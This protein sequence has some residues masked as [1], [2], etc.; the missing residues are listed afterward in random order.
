MYELAKKAREGMKAKARRLASETVGKVDSSTWSPAPLLRADIKTGARPIMKP[1]KKGI[2]ESNA[3][4][5]TK[6]AIGN[7]TR[8]AFKQGGAV[9]K[10]GGIL[11]KKA[12]G[13]VE[14]MPKRGAAQ[15]YKKGGRIKKLSG[16]TLSNYAKEAAKEL[17]GALGTYDSQDEGGDWDRKL[18]NR[19]QGI[20][21]AA[22]KLK[23]KGDTSITKKAGGRIKREDGGKLPSPYEAMESEARR[24][25][26][27]VERPA[28]RKLPSAKEAAES[29][30]RVG[31]V[32]EGRK[33][34]GK[35]KKVAKKKGGSVGLTV[36]IAGKDS[37]AAAP[38]G[39]AAPI[40]PRAVPVPP[41]APMPA[42][43]PAAPPPAA[44][45]PAP[46]GRKAGG[47]IT[48]VAKSYKD[49]EAGSGSG[50]GRL[51]KTDI[52]KKRKGAPTS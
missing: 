42:P 29:A 49:M 40:A 7:P 52:A 17:Y 35:S 12:V 18:Y 33:Y 37:K 27:K 8:G 46:M 14:V 23:R 21:L 3:A 13:A 19:K 4:R 30:A 44:M 15:N 24:K 43:M 34:G 39:M 47:R 36:V 32:P 9:K 5:D 25:T 22:E 6:A 26:I 41:S 51:Q 45:Q 10:D 1:S 28:D 20:G 16:G 31:D 38:Q 2:G 48:K 50:E 11:D